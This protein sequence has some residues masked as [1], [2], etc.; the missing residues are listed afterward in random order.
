LV[1]SNV[2]CLGCFRLA[3]LDLA[4]LA[5]HGDTSSASWDYFEKRVCYILKMGSG[6]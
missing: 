1:K 2:L 5:E 3:C 6:G 4:D